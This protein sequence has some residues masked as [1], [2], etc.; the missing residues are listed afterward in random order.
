MLGWKSKEHS[1]LQISF[2]TPH[3]PVTALPSPPVKGLKGE[4]F[5]GLG[6]V[7]TVEDRSSE[8]KQAIN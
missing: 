3:S 6:E 1:D 5:S 2:L 7:G 4:K 8:L